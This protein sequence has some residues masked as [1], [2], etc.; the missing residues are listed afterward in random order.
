[1]ARSL[2]FLGTALKVVEGTPDASDF[3]KIKI[4]E[5]QL[6]ESNSRQIIINSETQNQ[7]NR[8]TDTINKIINPRKND[9]VDTPHLFEALLARNRMLFTEIQNLILTITLA[10]PKIV[11]PTIL[12]HADLKSLVEQDTP[13]VSLL[14]ASKIRVLQS[15]NIIHILIAY[16]RFKSR[17]KNVAVYPVS[18]QHILLRLD[19]DTLAECKDDT[20]AVTGCIETTHHTFCER[21]RRESCARSLHAGNSAQCHTQPIHLQAITPL[22]VVIINE[23][24]AHVSTDGGPEILIKGTYLV[25]FEQTAIINGTEFVNIRKALS[26]QPRIVRSPLLHSLCCT[27]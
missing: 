1:M 6:V 12:D 7:I 5:A 23:A 14:K 13:I 22:D 10:K 25:T 19:D 9:L 24:T 15:A 4:T 20:F 17:C 16:P 26:K 2:D 18:H 8:L 21:T 11:N 3:L 27:D